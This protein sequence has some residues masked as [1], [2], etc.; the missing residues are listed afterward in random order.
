[1]KPTF[2]QVMGMQVALN[3]P[4]GIAMSVVSSICSNT[5]GVTTIPMSVIGIVVAIGLSLII[6]VGPICGG[7]CGLFV[8]GKNPMAYPQVFISVIPMAIIMTVLMEA[9]MTYL[10]VCVFGKQPFNPVFFEAYKHAFIPL[11]ITAYVCASAFLPWAM[12]VS[13]MDKATQR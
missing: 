8:K 5:L 2:K 11:V 6:P 7:F 1:M 4:L 10:G 12:K 13:G 3:V 9:V